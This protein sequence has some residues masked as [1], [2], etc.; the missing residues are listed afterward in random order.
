VAPCREREK[1]ERWHIE[2]ERRKHNFVPF[3]VQAMKELAARGQLS[4]LYE[5]G[6]Q[7]AKEARERARRERAA[8]KTAAVDAAG[9]GQGGAGRGVGGH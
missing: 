3:I 7:Q 2:N 1:F 8:A 5:R 9:G 4:A 6:K